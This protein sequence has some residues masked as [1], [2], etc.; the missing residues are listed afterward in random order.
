VI[1]PSNTARAVS[2]KTVFLDRDGVV[3]AKMPE[4]HWVTRWSE[5]HVL[6]GVVE[7]IAAMKRAGLRVVVVS[8]Q[9]GIALGRFGGHDVEAIHNQFQEMLEA[10]GTAV[11]GFYYCPH[12]RGQCNCRKPLPGLFEQALAASP[13]IRA[14][15]SLMIGDSKSDMEF[16]RRLGMMT[17][18]I[19]GD[20]AL[21]KPGVEAARALADMQASSLLDAAQRLLAMKRAFSPEPGSMCLGLP[22]K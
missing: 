3:N 5:F 12:D 16:G 14:D 17:V 4:G 9:R 10:S 22:A 15:T 7:A 20:P 18:F 8:N 13:G 2:L 11:D 6:P 19:D 21:Q 1:D